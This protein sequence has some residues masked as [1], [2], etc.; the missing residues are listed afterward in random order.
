MAKWR[1][2]SEGLDFEE[3]LERHLF[4][5]SSDP[6][7]HSTVVATRVLRSYANR[8]SVLACS[9]ATPY[10]TPADVIRDLIYCGIPLLEEYYLSNPGRFEAEAEIQR[11]LAEAQGM[12][13]IRE[14]LQDYAD[15]L[16]MLIANGEEEEVRKRLNRLLMHIEEAP[17]PRRALW[18]DAIRS[19]IQLSQWALQFG[20]LEQLINIEQSAAP[21]PRVRRA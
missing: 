6:Q 21:H 11:T 16:Q 10:R 19:N 17:K 14:Q 1:T 4:R 5:V 7:G 9:P 3:N 18:I 13:E 2:A 8:I 12:R 20:L 15:Y